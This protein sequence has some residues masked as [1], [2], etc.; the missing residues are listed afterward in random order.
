MAIFSRHPCQVV[1]N[2][3]PEPICLAILGSFSD[4]HPRGTF[5]GG[6]SRKARCRAEGQGGSVRDAAHSF[7]HTLSRVRN[8][9]NGT[10]SPFI[11]Q[12]KRID[13]KGGS[14]EAE[15]GSVF[16]ST[17][18]LSDK[19]SKRAASR[20]TLSRPIRLGKGRSRGERYR[21]AF[22]LAMITGRM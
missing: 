18:G 16:D 6:S 21:L 22:S 7:N 9:S 5:F 19:I 3:R 2:G 12:R 11:M 10:A 8:G 15:R 14:E 20:S 1:R 17:N 13:C 4:G